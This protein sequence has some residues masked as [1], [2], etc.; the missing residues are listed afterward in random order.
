MLDETSAEE[1]TVWFNL[2]PRKDSSITLAFK[3]LILITTLLGKK[4]KT[5]AK[6]RALDHLHTQLMQAAGQL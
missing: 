2:E 4:K 6:D 5:K 1:A 3:C